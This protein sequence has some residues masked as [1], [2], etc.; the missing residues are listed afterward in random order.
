MK[1][2]F[3][4]GSGTLWVALQTSSLFVSNQPNLVSRLDLD[5]ERH[6]DNRASVAE[7]AP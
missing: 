4:E 2:V 7:L 5:H 1:R 6:G 3:L